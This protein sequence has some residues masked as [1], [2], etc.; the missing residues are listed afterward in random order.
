MNDGCA[1]RS[2]FSHP[3]VFLIQ[4]GGL[5]LVDLPLVK[6]E[7]LLPGLV[8]FLLDLL[9]GGLLLPAQKVHDQAVVRQ[10]E[11]LVASLQFATV[12]VKDLGGNVLN[13]LLNGVELDLLGIIC[14]LELLVLVPAIVSLGTFSLSF[15]VGPLLARR[16]D[17]VDS[18]SA[19]AS[20]LL[21][22]DGDGGCFGSRPAAG[23]L[24][25]DNDL[26]AILRLDDDGGGLFGCECGLHEEAVHTG[27]A[28]FAG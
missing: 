19:A 23:L 1:V 20:F 13:Q 26:V 4:F 25:R 22:V 10:L 12:L 15:P 11:Q 6:A 16:F 27:L 28:S 7:G 2:F 9:L 8:Q 3:F 14:H 5:L 17:G 18:G 21:R 24:G